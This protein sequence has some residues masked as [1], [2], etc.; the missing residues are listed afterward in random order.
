MNYYLDV[1]KKYSVF[2]GRAG[3]K[4]FWM[5]VLFNIVI[6]AVLALVDNV[7]GLYF[8][9]ALYALLVLI[10]SLAVSVR[11]LHDI[12]R[13]GWW[14][15]IVLLPLIGFVALIIFWASESQQMENRYGTKL[16]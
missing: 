3:R 11:R 14:N 1:L 7:L 10:P 15:L 5:F 9:N 12:G 8:L 4:E 13:S 16:A 2:E 6:S